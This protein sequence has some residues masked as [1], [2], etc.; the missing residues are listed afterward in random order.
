MDKI[1]M[2]SKLVCIWGNCLPL[3]SRE[4]KKGKEHGTYHR[5]W[6]LGMGKKMETTKK[7]GVRK[8]L[9]ERSIFLFLADV[10]LAVERSGFRVSLVSGVGFKA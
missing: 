9:P 7:R 3:V 6:G 8:G 10:S 1:N 2:K 4:C 5:V